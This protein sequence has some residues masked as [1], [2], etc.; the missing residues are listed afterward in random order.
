MSQVITRRTMLATIAAAVCTPAFAAE[1]KAGELKHE[2][3]VWVL[4]SVQAGMD[5]E[6]V[7][8]TIRKRAKE[9]LEKAGVKVPEISVEQHVQEHEHWEREREREKAKDRKGPPPWAPAHGWRRKFGAQKEKDFG[10]YIT[11]KVRTGETGQVIIAAIQQQIEQVSKGGRVGDTPKDESPDRGNPGPEPG[12]GGVPQDSTG[13]TKPG[14]VLNDRIQS[15]TSKS[16]K[17]D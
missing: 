8:T 11:E 14:D 5:N 17:K 16:K 12:S 1:K 10:V 15:N 7:V 13:G 3:G 4:D 2:L 9:I 6:V